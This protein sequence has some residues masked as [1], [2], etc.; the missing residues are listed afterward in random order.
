MKKTVSLSLL[1]FSSIYADTELDEIKQQLKQQEINTKKLEDK[2][3]RLEQ[4]SLHVNNSASFSQNAYLPDMALIVNMSALSRDIKN[5]EYINYSIPGFIEPSEAQIPF[6]KDRGF[7]LNY[8]EFAI[9]SSVDP[10]FEVFA[11][12]HLHPNEFEIGEAYVQTRALPYGFFLKA[13][14]FKSSFGRINSK[15]QHSWNF[16][17][18]PIVYEALF[19]PDGISDAGVQLQYLFPTDTYIMAGFEA[20]QGTNERS[21]G[22]TQEN[23]LYVGY[24]KSSVDVSDDFSALGG[25]SIAH[26]KNTTSNIT[27]VYGID[28]TLR[29]QLDSYSALIFQ[30]EYLYRDKDLGADSA[31]QS[32]L[33]AEAIYQIDKNYSA[34]L[35]YDA[36]IQNDVVLPEGIDGD[37][38]QR[39]TAM[40]EYKPFEFSRLRLQ[41]SN[42]QTKVI[43]GERRDINEFILSLN[44]AAGAHGAHS[45]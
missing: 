23:N 15:H 30:A 34:G 35:R 14:K 21:F 4:E 41:Y 18:Q 43:D 17:S 40:L 19:G 36:I 2:V 33:Y 27:D 1:L 13:G 6:N 9:H 5:S 25:V 10:Y 7:N 28:M 42:D 38:L 32:G 37:N 16:D 11:N 29:E 44:I 26:G 8:A 22:D 12:F 3:T 31:K 20:L 24:L 45:Y 39:Y